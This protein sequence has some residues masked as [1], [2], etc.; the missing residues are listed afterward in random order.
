MVH[1]HRCLHT[2]ME[3]A[4]KWRLIAIKPVDGVELPHIP[5]REAAVLEPR[6]ATRLIEALRGTEYELPILVGLFCGTSPTRPGR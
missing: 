1:L 6:H 5:E 4:V 2:A 3:R